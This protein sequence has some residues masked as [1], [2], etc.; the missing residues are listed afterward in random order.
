MINLKKRSERIIPFL[1]LF[2]II[3]CGGNPCGLSQAENLL[4]RILQFLWAFSG[5]VAV[6]VVFWA[7][8]QLVTSAGDPAKAEGAKKTLFAGLIGVIIVVV[9]YA[10]TLVFANTVA[11]RTIPIPPGL[12]P[13][14]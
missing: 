7:A 3:N 1:Q 9:G 13:V 11:G 2:P 4:V 8:F 12:N 14:P 10:A 6:L 5:A